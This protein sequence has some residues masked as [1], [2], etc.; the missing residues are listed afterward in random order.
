MKA[1]RVFPLEGNHG[2]V[3]ILVTVGVI[4]AVWL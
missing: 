2:F 4:V 1:D 3:L